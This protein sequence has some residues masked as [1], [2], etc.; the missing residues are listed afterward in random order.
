MV[1]DNMCNPYKKIQINLRL[2]TNIPQTKMRWKIDRVENH[3][4]RRELWTYIFFLITI[5]IWEYKLVIKIQEYISVQ[6]LFK[7]DI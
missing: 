7:V 4:L 5:H 1:M 2:K 6:P 3:I